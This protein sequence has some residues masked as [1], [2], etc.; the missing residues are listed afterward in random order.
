MMAR[1]KVVKIWEISKANSDTP[2]SIF[3]TVYVN[4]FLPFRVQQANND[5]SA[6]VAS[7][8]LESDCVRHFGQGEDGM[9]PILAPKKTTDWET[10]I[11]ALGFTVNS[12]DPENTYFSASKNRSNKNTAGRSLACQYTPG[13][14]EG[15]SVAGKLLHLTY[16]ARAGKYFAWRLLR[17]TGL[18][19]VHDGKE[20]NHIARLGRELHADLLFGK[21]AIDHELVPVGEPP[22]APRYAATKRPPKQHYLSDASFEAAGGPCVERRVFPR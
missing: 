17:L 9:T 6:L 20:Q 7:V 2:G 3:T 11:D 13:R 18:H 21:W 19:D 15:G 8:S 22:S 12:H 5:H 16:V 1:V 4:D 10:T 14:G